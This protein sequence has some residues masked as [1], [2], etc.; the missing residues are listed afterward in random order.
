MSIADRWA[1]T[2]AGSFADRWSPNKLR[3][4]RAALGAGKAA[5]T[6]FCFIAL[7]VLIR[8]LNKIARVLREIGASVEREAELP[9]N[10]IPIK[11]TRQ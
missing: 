6:I 3:L 7:F 2:G 9:S 8:Q 1:N 11:G 10:V 5:M 4:N